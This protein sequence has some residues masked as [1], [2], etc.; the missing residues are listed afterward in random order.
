MKKGYLRTNVCVYVT[1]THFD[2]Y[3]GYLS[4]LSKDLDYKYCLDSIITD[5]TKGHMGRD[6]RITFK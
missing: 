6:K 1:G 4:S 2:Y 3:S 5:K